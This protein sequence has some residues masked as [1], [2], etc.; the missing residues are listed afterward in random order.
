MKT[1]IIDGL[2]LKFFYGTDTIPNTS[3]RNLKFG[4][5]IFYITTYINIFNL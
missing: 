2:D 4:G 3:S 5:F 1:T